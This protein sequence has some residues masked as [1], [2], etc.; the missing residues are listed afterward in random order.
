MF[1]SSVVY[2]FEV[3]TLRSPHEHA[4]FKFTTLAPAIGHS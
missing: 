3:R 1:E 2:E 4:N